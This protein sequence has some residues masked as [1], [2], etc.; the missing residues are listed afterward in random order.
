MSDVG[1]PSPEQLSAY[2]LGALPEKDAGR[3]AHH[4]EDCADCDTALDGLED[5]SD[6]L[7]DQ[8]RQ[9]ASPDRYSQEP[10][11][12]EA[13]A[14]V[15]DVE[16]SSRGSTDT[17]AVETIN[18][19]TDLGRLGDYEL[20]EELDHGGMGTVFRAMHVKLGREVALKVLPKGRMTDERAV[21]RFE[22]EMKA[23]GQLVHPN[24]VHATDAGEAEGVQFLA[25]ELI[26]GFDLGELVELCGP[27][28]MADACNLIAQAAVGLQIAHQAGLV[29]RDIKPSNLMVT[30]DGTLK[31][32]DLGLARF[33]LD[34]PAGREITAVGQPMGT[35]D[36]MAPEQVRDTHSV[37][38]RAD[39]YALGCTFYKLLTGQPPFGGEQY[40]SSIDKMMAHRKDAPPP[41]HLFRSELPN[42]LARILERMLDKAP[43]KRF[44]TPDKLA[45]ALAPFAADADLAGML[46][47]AEE[48]RE[49]LQAE[50]AL[51]DEARRGAEATDEH[52]DEAGSGSRAS[53]SRATATGSR[54]NGS[55]G[56]GT[57][58][59]TGTRSGRSAGSKT[60]TGIQPSVGQ[61]IEED[62]KRRR[63]RWLIFT[64]LSVTVVAIAAALGTW[65]IMTNRRLDQDALISKGGTG[66]TYWVPREIPEPAAVP[67]PLEIK[68][69]GDPFVETEDGGP[70]SLAAIVAEP[71]SI[72]GVDS[73]TIETRAHRGPIE[74]IA[75]SPDGR[76][77]ATGS[78]EGVIRL[79]SLADASLAGMLVGY[80]GAVRAL[81]WSPDG[82]YLA[83]GYSSEVIRLWEVNRRQLICV[84]PASVQ[85]NDSLDWSPDG[86]WLA[87]VAPRTDHAGDTVHVWEAKTARVRHVLGGHQSGVYAVAFS[88]DG[89][90]LATGGRELIKLWDVASGKSLR[91]ISVSGV[92]SENI[93]ALAWSPSATMIASSSSAP[94]GD[95]AVAFWEVETGQSLGR[96]PFHACGDR[97]LMWT[98]D[99]KMLIAASGHKDAKVRFWDFESQDFLPRE[100]SGGPGLLATARDGKSFVAVEAGGT[101]E[102]FD[103]ELHGEARSLGEHTGVPTSVAFSPDAKRLASGHEDRSV[104]FWMVDSGQLLRELAVEGRIG[105]V[106]WAPDGKAVAVLADAGREAVNGAARHTDIFNTDSGEKLFSLVLRGSQRI[107]RLDFSPDGRTIASVGDEWRIWEAAGETPGKLRS[108]YLPGATTL[109]WSPDAKI[110]AIGSEAGVTICDID[111]GAQLHEIACGEPHGLAMSPDAKIV[112]AVDGV[113]KTTILLLDVEAEE[114]LHE[115]RGSHRSAVEAMT[116]W[117]VEEKL[118]LVSGS[119]TEVCLW[120]VQS[121]RRQA[122]KSIAAAALSPKIELT[123]AVGPSMIRIYRFEDERLLRT[124]LSLDGRQYA[125]VS[126]EGHWT[127]S[128]KLGGEWLY[129]VQ[130]AKVQEMLTPEAFEKKYDWKN[131]QKLL[132]AKNE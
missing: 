110:L 85:G 111:S 4:L 98:S 44:A 61:F 89:N 21:A 119:A 7:I 81:E 126:P 66:V 105:A 130:A 70:L 97:S 53:G 94:T 16:G 69:P 100:L 79:W 26:E 55:R 125:V 14:R 38:I 52:S 37:D 42:K 27:L 131:D 127:G 122:M 106:R 45:E 91:N 76:L 112:A 17:M 43:E 67:K 80:D 96:L 1:C 108:S 123:A 18:E 117:T 124:I 102:V 28:R 84:I 47:R 10:E 40:Q 24:I 6:G 92:H 15:G 120:D 107:V 25:M 104:R 71:A 12:R 9:P 88:P 118:L 46:T 129:V 103:L 8:L 39:I 109:S 60:M 30:F 22:R 93:G 34:Q 90:T 115:L 83:A 65:A 32:L 5:R 116:W 74:S 31:I 48:A 101:L 62:R 82:R 23:V 114:T 2:L 57:G 128:R 58:T 20:I 50:Q 132:G 64:V 78:A 19:E 41:I 56:T 63:R 36:Y 87:H 54:S 33:Q 77:A 29:H 73:W 59:G 51:A 86:R 95:H 35:A 121:G 99:G 13:I 49:A 68:I 72:E 11:C 75:L 3:V 113:D